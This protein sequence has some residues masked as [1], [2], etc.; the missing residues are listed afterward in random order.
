MK[1]ALRCLCLRA[2]AA[3]ACGLH[4]MRVL[5]RFSVRY[6]AVFQPTT[7]GVHTMSVTHRETVK[8]LVD[9]VSVVD[10]VSSGGVP[11]TISGTINLPLTNT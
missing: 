9:G 1:C 6:R 8:L 7:A 4:L 5:R 11:V 2:L 10:A 3:G